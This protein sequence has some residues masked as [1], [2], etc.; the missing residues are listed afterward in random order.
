MR[1]KGIKIPRVLTRV[2]QFLVTIALFY[3]LIGKVILI[4]RLKY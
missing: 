3:Y 2:V 1:I 4:Q